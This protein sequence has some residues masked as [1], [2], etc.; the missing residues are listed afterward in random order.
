MFKEQE[1]VEQLARATYSL[2]VDFPSDA[3]ESELLELVHQRLLELYFIP[4]SW[5]NIVPEQ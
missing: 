4:K 5:I 3:F 2:G 1:W